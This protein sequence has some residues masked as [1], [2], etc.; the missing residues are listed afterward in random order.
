M[1]GGGYHH[2]LGHHLHILGPSVGK[3]VFFFGLFAWG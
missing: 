2:L 1:G 3:E